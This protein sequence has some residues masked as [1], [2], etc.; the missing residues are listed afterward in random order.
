MGGTVRKKLESLGLAEPLKRKAE[1]SLAKWVDGYIEGRTDVKRSTTLN[2]MA[3]RNNLFGF[4]NTNMSI[5][6]FCA[7]DARSFD[8]TCWIRGLLK[9]RYDGDAS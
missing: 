4:G 7:Y 1:I 3:A 5:T 6:D 8:D 2:M 9:I